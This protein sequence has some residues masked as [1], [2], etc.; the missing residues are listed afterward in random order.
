MW[1]TIDNKIQQGIQWLC[2]ENIFQ[3]LE[4][5]SGYESYD[6]INYACDIDINGIISKQIQKNSSD[7]IF[8][9]S[10]LYF[11]IKAS[12]I[13]HSF[14]FLCWQH[15]WQFPKLSLFLKGIEINWLHW[16]V[17]FDPVVKK[18]FNLT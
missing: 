18:S 5:I 8:H 11:L 12:K 7:I 10:M 6:M 4:I 9:D 13:Y 16:T 15:M 3:I 2:S 17:A 14:N 1:H